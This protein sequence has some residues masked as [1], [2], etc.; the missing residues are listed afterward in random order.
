MLAIETHGVKKTYTGA[1]GRRRRHAL[2]GVDLAV[3]RGTVF[4][5]IG[6]NGAGKT[7]FIKSLLSVIRP[8]AGQIRVL[9]GS[10]EDPVVR[11][12]IGYLPER[13]AL[14]RTLTPQKFLFGVGR[15][16]RVDNFRDQAVDLLAK[17]DLAGEEHTKIGSFSK[18]MRQRLGLAAALMGNPDLLI[19]DEP[20]DGVD[21]L[22]RA[23]IRRILER[24]RDRGTTVFINSHLLTETER[25]ASRVGIIIDGK[26]IKE[27]DLNA[28]CGKGNRW[29]AILVNDD[30]VEA[31]KGAG[32]VPGDQT[33]EWFI[34]TDTVD[35]MN[36]AVTLA[37]TNGARFLSLIPD[38]RSL[39][40]V[41]A[42]ETRNG[43]P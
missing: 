38:T 17:M 34:E 30:A 16:K 18:G 25:L 36:R 2:Q 35:D 37:V 40:E 10:P 13:L 23:D 5:L 9:G 27:G 33:N 39:E 22:G 4:G 41:L 21:P 24:E 20:T 12:R 26:I 14:P 28:L 19:L 7:T 31:V 43:A 11:S 6:L 42:A 29:R 1:F 3:P 8:D 15:I 32:F